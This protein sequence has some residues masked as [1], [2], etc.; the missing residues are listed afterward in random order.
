MA[1][2]FPIEQCSFITSNLTVVTNENEPKVA[3]LGLFMSINS[4]TRMNSIHFF[5]KAQTNILPRSMLWPRYL[6]YTWQPTVYNDG[7]YTSS[8]NYDRVFEID[9]FKLWVQPKTLGPPSWVIDFATTGASLWLCICEIIQ[10]QLFH[11]KG[12]GQSRPSN[13][14]SLMTNFFLPK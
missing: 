12:Y 13:A 10:N 4:I 6:S 11:H 7:P 9:T 2:G 3:W 8:P 5:K 14:A 1:C